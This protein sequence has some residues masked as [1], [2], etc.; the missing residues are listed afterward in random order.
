MGGPVT[1]HEPQ[2]VGDTLT[3]Y[4][5]V[6]ARCRRTEQANRELRA[7]VAELEA[8]EDRG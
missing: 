3:T 2:P 5:R 4:R 6:L 7:Q 8:Q 1:E